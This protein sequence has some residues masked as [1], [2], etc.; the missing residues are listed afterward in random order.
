MQLE[1][2]RKDLEGHGIRIAAISNDRT[3]ALKHFS[4]RMNLGFPLLSDPESA[5]IREFG[6]LNEDVPKDHQFFGIP[7]P[8]ELLVDPDRTVRDRFHEESYRDRFTAGRVLVRQL[9]SESGASRTTAPTSHLKEWKRGSP[10]SWM[11]RTMTC[12][13][14]DW[15]WRKPFPGVH[16]M[17]GTWA[18][19]TS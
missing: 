16:W 7:H 2:K 5:I 18:S 11:P 10:N 1:R 4:D 9:G 17:S 8:V 12:R 6:V 15:T 3:D 13:A 14:R 19:P